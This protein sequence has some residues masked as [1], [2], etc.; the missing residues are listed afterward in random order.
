MESGFV[1]A[2]LELG[3][4]GFPFTEVAVGAQ[5][6]KS[7]VGG[8]KL[9]GKGLLEGFK[10]AGKHGLGLVKYEFMFFL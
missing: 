4:I 1:E 8:S 7:S 5:G 6:E 3:N 9:V 2:D 10:G